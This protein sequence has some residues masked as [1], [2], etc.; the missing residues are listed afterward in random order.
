MRQ[1]FIIILSLFMISSAWNHTEAQSLM[2]TAKRAEQKAKELK[3]QEVSRYND[4][5]DSK[6]LNK[7]NQFIA[8]YPKGSM[9]PEIRNRVKEIELWNKTKA[10]NNSEDYLEAYEGYL[11][12]TQYHW[13]DQEAESAIRTIKRNIERQEWNQVSAKNSISAYKQYL[14]DHPN[15]GFREDAEKALNRLEG[16]QAWENIN[17]DNVSELENFINT[18]PNAYEIKVAT[19]RLHELKGR[20][21]YDR[22]DMSKAYKEFSQLSRGNISYSNQK[23]YDDVMEYHEF[24]MLGPTT[25]SSTIIA[26]LNKYPNGKYHN[27]ASNILAI[28]KARSFGDYATQADYNT[29]LSYAKDRATIKTVQ[30]YISLNKESQNL[31][32]KRQRSLIRKQNGGTVNLGVEFLDAGFQVNEDTD[33][34][35]YNFGLFVRFGNYSDRVQFALGIKPGWVSHKE[36]VAGEYMDTEDSKFDFHMPVLG[37]LKLNLFKMTQESRFFLYGQYQYNAVRIKDVEASMAWGAGF[38]FAW[39]H[40]DLSFYYR[41]DVGKP[42]YEP[43]YRVTEDYVISKNKAKGYVGASMIWYLQL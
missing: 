35:Y 15:S 28:Q 22:G 30:S 36:Y 16:R 9:T 32:K 43:T 25:A 12:N 24:Y 40:F 11:K 33:I 34:W 1:L 23:A 19:S 20:D 5:L 13:Y 17:R 3:Q 37:Q 31:R 8:D 10:L 2:Q 27:Q 26:F 21:Y 39:K 4:I 38:G 6:D 14:T 29:A 42:D 41:Q 7:Y 18:Y